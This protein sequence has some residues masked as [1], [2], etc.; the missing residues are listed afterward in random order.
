M[1]GKKKKKNWREII[2]HL[3]SVKAISFSAIY[4]HENSDFIR[5]KY[6]ENVS[7]VCWIVKKKKKKFVLN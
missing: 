4:L 1:T 5:L 3:S 7:A 6:D 2:F